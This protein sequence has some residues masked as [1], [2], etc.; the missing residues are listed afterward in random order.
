MNPPELIQNLR[1]YLDGLGPEAA[2]PLFV[3][4]ILCVYLAIKN[5]GSRTLFAFYA[6]FAACLMMLAIYIVT[7]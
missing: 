4:A 5:D 7:T 2:I 1:D 6:F 3:A